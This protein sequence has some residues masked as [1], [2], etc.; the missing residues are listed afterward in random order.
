MAPADPAFYRRTHSK[1]FE[2]VLRWATDESRG[3][4]P[5]VVRPPFTQDNVDYYGIDTLVEEFIRPSVD[6]LASRDVYALIDFHP[7]RPYTQDATETYNEENDEELAPIG[8]V[9]ETFWSAV[10]PSSPTTNTS[11]TVCSTSRPSRRCT[12][13]TPVPGRPGATR[14]SPGST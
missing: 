2:E 8:D 12:A 9:M 3:W 5:N 14:P 1:S 13:T 7:I 6:L 4:H 10:A 11:S